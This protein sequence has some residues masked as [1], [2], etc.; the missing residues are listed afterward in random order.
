MRSDILF[1]SVNY[2]KYDAE[3]TLPAKFSRL[4]D[5]MG[6]CLSTIVPFANIV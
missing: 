5:K 4:V 1:A 6:R 2:E 3:A